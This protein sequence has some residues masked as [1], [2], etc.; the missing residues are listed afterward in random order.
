[1]ESFNGHLKGEDK[2]LFQDAANLW[3]L[4]RIIDSRRRLA[5]RGQLMGGVGRRPVARL[6]LSAA[7]APPGELEC[8]PL[9]R[10]IARRVPPL[11]SKA[12]EQ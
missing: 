2:S 7:Q 5:F 1:M 6:G 10:C 11:F 8:R 12:R 9:P 3:E 4:E